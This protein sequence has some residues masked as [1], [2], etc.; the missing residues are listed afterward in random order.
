MSKEKSKNKLNQ[1]LDWHEIWEEIAGTT[2]RAAAIVGEAILDDSLSRLLSNYFVENQD[3]VNSIMERGS[4]S[5]LRVKSSIAYCL[6]LISK[7]QLEDFKAIYSIRNHFAHSLHAV[8][9]DDQNV[10]KHISQI[11]PYKRF[12][13]SDSDSPRKQFNIAVSIIAYSISVTTALTEHRQEIRDK[14]LNELIKELT[15]SSS[16]KLPIA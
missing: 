11:E 5:S 1:T 4:L 3:E 12:L 14:N 9:F 10:Y 7:G 16:L 2:D 15:S 8:S 6:G 13:P